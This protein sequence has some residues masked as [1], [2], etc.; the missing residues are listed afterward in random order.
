MGLQKAKQC[1]STLK[2]SNHIKKI[3]SNSEYVAPD[4]HKP[5]C[6][7]M[8]LCF[9]MLKAAVLPCSFIALLPF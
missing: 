3:K 7:Y 8:C 2:M 9:F 4:T 1:Q 5:T 6:N